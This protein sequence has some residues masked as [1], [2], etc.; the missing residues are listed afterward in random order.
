MFFLLFL[1]GWCFWPFP[2]WFIGHLKN[3]LSCFSIYLKPSI[4][5]LPYSLSLLIATMT[6]PFVLLETWTILTSLV[7][8]IRI[9][10]PRKNR[11]CLCICVYIRL[12]CTCTYGT[13]FDYAEEEMI[14]FHRWYCKPWVSWGF[15]NEGY[16]IQSTLVTEDYPCNWWFQSC[17]D[18]SSLLMDQGQVWRISVNQN[19]VECCWKP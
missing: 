19:S 5:V 18:E 10:S 11:A 8:L 15:P 9:Y 2:C 1:L 13:A 6:S 3:W 7:F 4:Q 14:L 17:V 12:W 16:I